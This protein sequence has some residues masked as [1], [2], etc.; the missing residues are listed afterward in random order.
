M[1]V[2]QVGARLGR[3]P[4]PQVHAVAAETQRGAHTHTLPALRPCNARSMS[5]CMQYAP[6]FYPPFASG[7]GF[8]LSRDLVQALLVQPL[9]DYRLLVR[10]CAT[11][12]MH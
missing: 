3:Q 4:L 10:W 8:V 1:P 2:E 6:D 11:A 9:P 7:C 5:H 12:C